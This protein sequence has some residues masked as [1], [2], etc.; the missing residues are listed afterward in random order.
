MAHIVCENV[1]KVFGGTHPVRAL[2]GLSLE[3][4]EGEVFGLLGPNGS[5][6]TTLVR[7]CLNI[8]FPTSGQLMVLGKKPG[9]PQA[10][11]QIGYLPEN[12]NFY[13]HLT[14]RSFLYYHAELAR[15]PLAERRPR[16]E[17]VLKEVHLEPSAAGRRLRTYSKGM[18]QRI[19]LA[20]A[21][22]GRPKLVFLDEP[23]TGLDPIGRSQIK[24]TMRRMALSGT[25]VL[26]SSHVLGDV[27]AVADRIA[28]IDKGRL[29]KVATLDELTLH[30]NRI[31]IRLGPHKEDEKAAPMDSASEAKLRM[32]LDK[33]G[34]G[35]IEFSPNAITCSLKEES[36]TPKLVA[37]LAQAGFSLYEVTHERMSLE[38]VFLKEFGELPGSRN[39]DQDTATKAS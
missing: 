7:C 26:F 15:V 20:Q 21:M 28:I 39:S 4:Q 14:G 18:L 22:V 33:T 27:E 8:I 30:T 34:A 9:N 3:V 38:E 24:D 29:R 12:P 2:D 25:T 13:D 31:H 36:D 35:S 32:I 37:A 17:E 11:R 5:G 1:V 16:V 19:G 6:K 23:Q 10:A